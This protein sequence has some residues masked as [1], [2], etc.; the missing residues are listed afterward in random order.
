MILSCRI[1]DNVVDV[2]NF[3]YVNQF[4]STQGDANTIYFQLMD[5]SVDKASGGFVPPGRRYMPA[6]GATLIVIVDT[7][8]DAKK[9]NRSAVQ[10]FAT[11]DPS[12]WSFQILS[13]DPI[14][15]TSNLKLTLSEGLK[16][17]RGVARTA[18]SISPA[19]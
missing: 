11:Q 17:T 3:D 16:I 10:P 6:V 19:Q 8:D 15:G 5:A 9:I 2:N 13:T 1:L 4:E 12:L 18:I 14:R 7:L